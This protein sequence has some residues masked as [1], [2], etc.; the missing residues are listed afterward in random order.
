MYWFVSHL[1]V[2]I[3]PGSS[4][5][6][7]YR[8]T[9]SFSI[10][11]CTW[12]QNRKNIFLFPQQSVHLVVGDFYLSGS[13]GLPHLKREVCIGQLIIKLSGS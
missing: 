5:G 6:V 7:P 13:G 10:L 3:C 2:L 8:D 12:F 11:K 4:F 1:E 9:S